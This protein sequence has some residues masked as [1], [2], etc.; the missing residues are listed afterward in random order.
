MKNLTYDWNLTDIYKTQQEFFV[1]YE[2]YKSMLKEKIQK[3][4]G[5]LSSKNNVL[6]YFKW[7][8]EEEKL[9]TKVA[10]Y[11]Y[12]CKALDGKDE[13]ARKIDGEYAYF[14][15][16]LSPKLVELEHEIY[17]VKNSV[18]K[19][20]LLDPAFKDYDLLL[21]DIILQKKHKQSANVEAV[22]A[23][24]TAFGNASKT[25]DAFDDIDVKYGFVT[26]PEGERVELT[27]ANYGK[28]IENP[29]QK[30]RLKVFNRMLGVFKN[31]NY[32]LGELYLGSVD[33]NSFFVEINKYKNALEMNSK[34]NKISTKILPNLIEVVNS[35]FNLFYR[36]QSIKKKYLNLKKYYT[37]DNLLPIGKMDKNFTY[38]EGTQL[39]LNALD[40]LGED[41]LNVVKK[42]MTEGWIDVYHKPAKNSGGFSMGVYGVHPYI[43]INFNNTYDWV[44]A[45]AHE[46]GHTMH[47]YYS[48]STQPIEKSDYSI[49]VA[50]IASVVNEIL[51]SNYMLKKCVNKQEKL[52][53]MNEI[54]NQFYTTLYRQTMFSEF[55]H[56][57]YTAKE[58]K[59][60]LLVEDLNNYYAELQDKYFGKDVIKTEFAKYEWSRVP[61]FYRPYYVYKYATGFISACVIANNL[62]NNVPG[63]KE[64]YINFL[65]AGSSEYPVEILKTVGVDLTKKSTLQG[66][67]DLYK[68]YLD[69]FEDLVKEEEE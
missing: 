40:V 54:L 30:F 49:F 28:L 67:F 9:W 19:Q 63:Y 13:F 3:F 27:H 8:T 68:K 33:E 44:S 7:Q 43:L 51:L 15:K 10:S 64:K 35:N 57:V 21:D 12:L 55:E 66:A 41:Y 24:N 53:C 69:Q 4:N 48:D 52:F 5:K 6:E 14:I 58:K 23:K 16:D 25:F 45:L 60:P 38:A 29:D 18:L 17:K 42:A 47:S 65:S 36:F 46:L 34:P 32:T 20:W 2:K 62:L 50:E 61:H 31:F 59:Q 22:L 39:V 37:F 56:F 11:V 26:T 1:D